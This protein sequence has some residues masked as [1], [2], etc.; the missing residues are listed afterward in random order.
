MKADL[1]LPRPVVGNCET[2]AYPSVEGFVMETEESAHI[3]G[4][5]KCCFVFCFWTI[6]IASLAHLP[7]SDH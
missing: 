2:V 4:A 5:L 3:G 1:H 6:L 7:E